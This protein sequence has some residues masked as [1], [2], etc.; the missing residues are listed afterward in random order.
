MCGAKLSRQYRPTSFYRDVC[1]PKTFPE[2]FHDFKHFFQDKTQISWDDRLEGIRKNGT[3]VY[4]PPVLGRPV[5]D[6]KSGYIR[7]EWRY[8]EAEVEY[9]TDSEVGDD[10]EDASENSDG[11]ATVSGNNSTIT[12][13]SGED[14][15]TTATTAVESP[16]FED[17]EMI[18]NFNVQYGHQPDVIDGRFVVDEDL[19]GQ[20][21]PIRVS[22]FSNGKVESFDNKEV[23][24]SLS[25][26]PSATL[27]FTAARNSPPLKFEETSRTTN[28]LPQR[29]RQRSVIDL[30]SD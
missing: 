10:D 1:R 29:P 28:S 20:Q 7:P 8:K 22:S 6:V 15:S 23:K 24:S 2:A 19:Y 4:T 18:R 11:E 5:G 27:S 12:I 30:T 17:S 16:T 9:D 3:F 14:S 13:T 26:P 21:E 25:K